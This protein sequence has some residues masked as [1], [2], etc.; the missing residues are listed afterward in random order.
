MHV[1]EKALVALPA[2]NQLVRHVSRA[3]ITR[4]SSSLEPD[5][6]Q[7]QSVFTAVARPLSVA[8]RQHDELCVAFV[9]SSSPGVAAPLG[10]MQARPRASRRVASSLCTAAASRSCLGTCTASQGLRALVCLLGAGQE[11]ER[12]ALVCTCNAGPIG[13][14]NKQFICTEH[15]RARGWCRCS[16]DSLAPGGSCQDTSERA[17]TH[18]HDSRATSTQLHQQALLARLF[19]HG[20]DCP[21]LHSAS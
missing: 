7:A 14:D 4:H 17:G 10:L 16:S 21:C 8:S 11:S 19:E 18:L 2:L 1:L 3:S 9:V 13:A 20:D 6:D 12:A 15:Q 5:A